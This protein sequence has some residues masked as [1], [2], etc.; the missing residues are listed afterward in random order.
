MNQWH[1]KTFIVKPVPAVRPSSVNDNL[2]RRYYVTVL[3][4]FLNNQTFQV[5]EIVIHIHL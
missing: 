1:S 5:Q 2:R 4:H 3:I